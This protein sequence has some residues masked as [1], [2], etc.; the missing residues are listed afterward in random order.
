M[1]LSANKNKYTSLVFIFV[2][3]WIV[4]SPWQSVPKI[5]G[6]MRFPYLFAPLVFCWIV[7]F[8]REYILNLFH[9]Y[10]SVCLTFLMIC[11]YNSLLL[12]Y[13]GFS[14]RSVG[15]LVWLIFNFIFLISVQLFPSSVDRS[16]TGP[17][18]SRAPSLVR[19]IC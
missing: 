1:E 2:T 12:L 16:N 13:S 10:K 18:A 7:F 11:A 19:V 14:T 15:F 5:S 9:R 8:N 17:I 6:V 3:A 4:A